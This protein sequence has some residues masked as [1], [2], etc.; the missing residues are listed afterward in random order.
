[1]HHLGGAVQQ[2]VFRDALQRSFGVLRN[3]FKIA[4]QAGAIF[5]NPA[6]DVHRAK[7]RPK[8]LQLP[9]ARQFEL[10]IKEIENANGRHSRKCADLVRFLAFGGFRIRKQATSLGGIAILKKVKLSFVATNPAQKIG[11]STAF[12]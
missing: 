5:R 11:V 7:V 12:R 10:F 3:V 1:M 2:P 4:I 6:Q 8:M 9:D